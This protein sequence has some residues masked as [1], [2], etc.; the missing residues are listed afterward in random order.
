M[1][2]LSAIVNTNTATP[3]GKQPSQQQQQQQQQQQDSKMVAVTADDVKYKRKYKDLKK[4][5]RD[6][7][8][9][10]DVL[11]IKLSRA[12]KNIHRL[13]VE[14]SF[15]FD[16]LD[17]T[18]HSTNGSSSTSSSDTDSDDDRNGR[19][20]SHRHGDRLKSHLYRPYGSSNRHGS[21]SPPSRSSSIA[22]SAQHSASSSIGSTQ[23]MDPSQVSL[24]PANGK[25]A[26]K[27]R[28]K[29]PLAPKRPSNAFFIFSQQHRQQAREEKKEGN[30]SELTKF[31]GQR[32]KSMPSTEKKIYSELAVRDR[33]RYL[34]EMS[35]YQTEG[36]SKSGHDG[37][38]VSPKK[39]GK[40]GRP[41]K[42]KVAVAT[43]EATSKTAKSEAQEPRQGNGHAS[44]NG[45]NGLHVPSGNREAGTEEA[46][47]HDEDDIRMEATEDDDEEEEDDD[48]GDRDHDHDHEHDHDD[49]DDEEEVENH[50]SGSKHGGVPDIEMTGVEHTN[51]YASNNG[52]YGHH[53]GQP[54]QVDA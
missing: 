14:R 27:K 11:N 25:R 51:G 40:P 38:I 12:R 23:I 42:V 45:T 16:R 5:I 1:A 29:D 24:S 4:R 18:G 52:V 8:E 34:D 13:R 44:S 54:Q 41:P 46:S 10:N 9:D 20:S 31:L 30:Q 17:Q 19:S 35:T 7:E 48:E 53:G 49:E 28:R 33:Q 26:I 39:K 43:I 36:F 21:K 15:L 50:V 6:I 32:W 3:K 37:V 47:S 2:S 22:G